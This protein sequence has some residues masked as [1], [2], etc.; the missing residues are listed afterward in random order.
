MGSGKVTMN[1]FKA[2][3]W[4]GV[5]IGEQAP[6]EVNVYVE[7]VR[8]DTVKYELDKESGLLKVDRPQRFSNMCPVHY[9]FAPQTYCGEKVAELF[10]QRTGKKGLVGDGDPLD[11]CVLAETTLTHGDILVRAIPIGGLSLIDGEEADD[12]IIAIMRGDAAYGDWKDI[13]D[14]PIAVID[15]LKHYFLTYKQP[16]GAITRRCEIAGSYGREEAY[17]VIAAS[18]DDYVA[19]FPESTS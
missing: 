14:C 9:G 5:S 8:T 4:H 6:Q 13:T 12:K 1:L 16:P 7:I 2:H 11:I 19:E 10:T 17:R 15:K 3:P 18:H